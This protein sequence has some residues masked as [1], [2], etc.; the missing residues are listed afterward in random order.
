MQGNF[1]S[2][3]NSAES[4]K[5]KSA[6]HEFGHIFGIGHWLKG[7]MKKGSTRNANEIEITQGNIAKKE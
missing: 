4:V 1:C 2:V 3:L 7:L 6:A 5:R